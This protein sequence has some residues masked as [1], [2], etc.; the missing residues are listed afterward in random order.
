[1]RIFDFSAP[2]SGNEEGTVEWVP[3][4]GQEFPGQALACPD[5]NQ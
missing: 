3:G 2:P 4:G 5:G 1:M